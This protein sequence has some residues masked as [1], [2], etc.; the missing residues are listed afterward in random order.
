MCR[1]EGRLEITASEPR[2]LL[3]HLCHSHLPVLNLTL[4]HEPRLPSVGPPGIHTHSKYNKVQTQAETKAPRSP[5]PAPLGRWSHRSRL[6]HKRPAFPRICEASLG[7]TD[8][9]PLSMQDTVM[10]H[11]G[12]LYGLQK[13]DSII[14]TTRQTALSTYQRLYTRADFGACCGTMPGYIVPAGFWGSP[15]ALA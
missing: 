13:C 6:A 2:P 4:P 1:G 14:H 3:V 8:S 7:L 10:V 5:Y 12:I 9:L 11:A 15:A